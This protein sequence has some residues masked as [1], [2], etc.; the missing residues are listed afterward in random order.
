MQYVDNSTNFSIIKLR[1]SGEN[2]DKNRQI[3]STLEHDPNFLDFFKH[4]P[5]PAVERFVL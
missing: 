2:M 5:Q 3:G 1:F 4:F